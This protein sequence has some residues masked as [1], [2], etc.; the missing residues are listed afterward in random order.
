MKC[1]LVFL[2]FF[3]VC[4][5]AVDTSCHESQVASSTLFLIGCEGDTDTAGL[6]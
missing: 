3:P 5:P 4:I 1:S 2:L 6:S